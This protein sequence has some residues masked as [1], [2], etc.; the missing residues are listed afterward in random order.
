MH[1]Q[2]EVVVIHD[3]NG[4]LLQDGD[5]VTVLK[6]L[7]TKGSSQVVK[8]G[9]KVKNFAWSAAITTSIAAASMASARCSSSPNS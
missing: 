5:S 6:D 8:V 7:R 2:A 3:A 9:T 1:A 4:N